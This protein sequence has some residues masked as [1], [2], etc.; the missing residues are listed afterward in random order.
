MCYNF[1]GDSSMNEFKRRMH[2]KIKIYSNKLYLDKFFE[3]EFEMENGEAHLYLYLNDKSDLI[4]YRTMGKQLSLNNDIYEYIDDKTSM[5]DN[6]VK[7][8]LHLRCPEL[9][10]YDKENV[11][12]IF[13]E[14]FAI[15]LYKIQKSYSRCRNKTIGL[16]IIGFISFIIYILLC[17][18]GNNLS[19][20]FTEIFAFLFSFSLW[21]AI[22]SLIYNLS[23]TRYEVGNVT[24]NLL[25]EIDFMEDEKIA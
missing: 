6:D 10:N 13:K 22:D 3:D 17:L 21:E 14:H 11:K 18:Y 8:I 12:H 2:E 7:I 23:D 20:M 15:E 25:I 19:I 16:A 24:Q 4:D 5:L 9:D 1:Y